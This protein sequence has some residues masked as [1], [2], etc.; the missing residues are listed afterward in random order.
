MGKQQF[1][2]HLV[3]EP[4]V[5]SARW[6]EVEDMEVKDVHPFEHLAM[7]W[8]A[9]EQGWNSQMWIGVQRIA[10]P[11]WK[12]G[13]WWPTIISEPRSYLFDRKSEK[14]QVKVTKK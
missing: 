14:K 3:L 13:S 2:M 5:G 4:V 10:A 1:Q 6:S 7:G 8:R 11:K 12:V 9:M